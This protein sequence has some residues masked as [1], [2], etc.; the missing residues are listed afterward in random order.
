MT[1]IHGLNGPIESLGE[2]EA[3]ILH[4]LIEAPEGALLT[5]EQIHE[6][7]EHVKT[8]PIYKDRNK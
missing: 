1:R 2:A 5:Q 8:C 7:E 3:L 6:T 4:Q